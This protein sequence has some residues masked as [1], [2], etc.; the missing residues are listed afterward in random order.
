MIKTY[1]LNSNGAINNFIHLTTYVRVIGSPQ[2][3]APPAVT[4]PN[5][6]D[7]YPPTTTTTTAVT[8]ETETPAAVKPVAPVAG[9]EGYAYTVVRA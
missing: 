4:T 5:G 1:S 2:T 8:M 7:F 9:S 6:A 3:E